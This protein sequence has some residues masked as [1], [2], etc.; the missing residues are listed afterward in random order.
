MISLFTGVGEL[1]TTAPKGLTLKFW[2]IYRIQ[3]LGVYTN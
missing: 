1:H 3:S 2:N